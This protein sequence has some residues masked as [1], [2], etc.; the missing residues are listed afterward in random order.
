[1]SLTIQEGRNLQTICSLDEACDFFCETLAA[2]PGLDGVNLYQAALSGE[3]RKYSGC[4]IYHLRSPDDTYVPTD[5]ITLPEVSITDSI[6]SVLAQE[7]INML[8]PLK[9]LNPIW[10]T[11]NICKGPGTLVP[12]FGI[13]LNAAAGN[14]PAYNKTI[15]QL[16]TEDPPDPLK[17][18]LLPEMHERI[19]H[20][21]ANTPA[22]FKINMPDLQGPFNLLHS[23]VGVEAFTAPYEQEDLFHSIMERITCFWIEVRRNFV[24]H[25]GQDRLSPL[26][27]YPRI[28]ECSVNLVSADFY[29]R[30]ILPHDRRIAE[31]FGPL[32]I[33]PCAGPHVFRVTLENLP[34]AKTEA[35]YHT[36][37]M[38]AGSTSVDEALSLIK[39]REILLSIGQ[40]LPAGGELEMIK[41]DFDRYREYSRLTFNYTGMHW[42]KKDRPLIREIHQKAEDYWAMLYA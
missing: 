5:E 11:F 40:E 29:R 17:S 32:Y 12:S 30:F 41:R 9:I 10:A 26:A 25:I 37:K 24:S 4:A 7:V 38:T 18:G 2:H 28:A 14:C 27:K 21:K 1:M 16:L 23:M 22:I 39:G 15:K 6:E 34:V 31:A 36:E 42:R 3:K 20:I 19:D 35:G 13:P 8:E 33:H